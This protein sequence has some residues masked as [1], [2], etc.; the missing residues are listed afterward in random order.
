MDA[1]DRQPQD[2]ATAEGSHLR[3]FLIGVVGVVHVGV[4]AYM[5]YNGYRR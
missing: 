4:H 1:D 5:D 3:Q 2:E